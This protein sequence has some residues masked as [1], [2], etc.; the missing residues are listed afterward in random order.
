LDK[1]ILVNYTFIEFF[2]N[3]AEDY[4]KH[5]YLYQEIYRVITT[6]IAAKKSVKQIGA[7]PPQRKAL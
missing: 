3:L 7:V 5:T 2:S 4:V 6:R 1:E